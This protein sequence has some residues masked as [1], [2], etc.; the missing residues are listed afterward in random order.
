MSSARTA[1]YAGTFD[2][3]TNGHKDIIER[4]AKVFEHVIVAV[5]DGGPK[6]TLFTVTDRVEMIRETA[7]TLSAKNVEVSSFQGL[8]VKYVE[9]IGAKVIVRGLRAVS[10]YEYEAQLA[11]INR[12]LASDIETVYLVTSQRCSFISASIV[13]ELAKYGGDISSMV[14]KTVEERLRQRFRT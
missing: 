5:V 7:Q 8:L 13:R 11:M 1:V 14:P 2:P 4:A 12:Q 10:D 6:Q 9:Q 3:I